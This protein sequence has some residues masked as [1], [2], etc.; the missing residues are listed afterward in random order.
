MFL[1]G[2]SNDEDVRERLAREIV[3]I[4][5]YNALTSSCMWTCMDGIVIVVRKRNDQSR[6]CL[7]VRTKVWFWLI[8]RSWWSW[9]KAT[10]RSEWVDSELR[11]CRQCNTSWF[12][13]WC[14]FSPTPPL[15]FLIPQVVRRSNGRRSIMVSKRMFPWSI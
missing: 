13:E 12:F 7:G 10:T 8:P 5:E 1:L 15:S 2:K 6:I 3:L 9:K 4:F 14:L 11:Q